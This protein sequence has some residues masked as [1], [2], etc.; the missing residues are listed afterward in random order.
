MCELCKGERKAKLLDIW[1]DPSWMK[2]K[3]EIPFVEVPCLECDKDRFWE[4]VFVILDDKGYPLKDVKYD[5]EGGLN[6]EVGQWEHP[7]KGLFL[8]LVVAAKSKAD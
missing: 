4:E 1:A 6:F 3:A 7:E 8:M 5:A 2:T